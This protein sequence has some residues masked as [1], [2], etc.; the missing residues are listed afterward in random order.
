MLA[1]AQTRAK[2]QTDVAGSKVQG[3]LA[4][5]HTEQQISQ[6]NAM[7]KQ[8]ERQDELQ[9]AMLKYAHETKQTL[10]QV[11][12]DL[13]KTSMVETTKRQL[14]AASMQLQANVSLSDRTH[15]LLLQSA[16]D[17]QQPIQ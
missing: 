1:V 7:A 2:A 8:H 14:A 4:Y 10:E 9:L 3:E 5:A 15:D 11:K 13:A 17:T 6:Q 12:A 16:S